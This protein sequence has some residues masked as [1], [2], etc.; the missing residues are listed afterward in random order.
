MPESRK[1]FVSQAFTLLISVV[2]AIAIMLYMPPHYSEVQ[3]VPINS[4]SLVQFSSHKLDT[5]QRIK[6]L[7]QALFEYERRIMYLEENS[8]LISTSTIILKDGRIVAGVK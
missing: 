4:E 6:R 7:E 1:E 2:I 5:N 8:V 3:S